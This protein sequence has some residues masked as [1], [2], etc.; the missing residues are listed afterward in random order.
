[1]G[2]KLTCISLCPHGFQMAASNIAP[3]NPPL[4]ESMNVCSPIPLVWA[5]PGDSLLMNRMWPKWW[6]VTS[7][8]RSQKECGFRLGLPLWGK[9]ATILWEPSGE[10]HMAKNWRK[11][12]THGQQVSKALQSNNLWGTEYC[13]QHT[14]ELGSG[15]SPSHAFRYHPDCNLGQKHPTKLYPDKCDP[16]KQWDNKRFMFQPLNSEITW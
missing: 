7:E 10:T 4:L 16:E 5:G 1:M 6:D 15:S 14:S 11:L 13:W 8:I 3:D 12:P 9:A 2:V